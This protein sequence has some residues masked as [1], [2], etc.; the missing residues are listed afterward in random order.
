MTEVDCG[1]SNRKIVTMMEGDEPWHAT[2][3]A[4]RGKVVQCPLVEAVPLPMRGPLSRLKHIGMVTEIATANANPVFDEA[5][6][7][8]GV[9][10][11]DHR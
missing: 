11:R 7:S 6:E 10:A 3:F 9:L 8:D 2:D 1:K 4:A 5:I